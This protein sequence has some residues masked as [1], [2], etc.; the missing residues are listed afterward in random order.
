MLPYLKPWGTSEKDVND[1]NSSS[2]PSMDFEIKDIPSNKEDN[3]PYKCYNQI[4]FRFENADVEQ[5]SKFIPRRIVAT[6]DAIETLNRSGQ[7][8]REFIIRH[9]TGDWGDLCPED[10]KTNDEMVLHQKDRNSLCGKI[11]SSYR[12]SN[13]ERIWIVTDW[14]IKNPDSSVTCIL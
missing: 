9:V 4:E 6:P 1:V 10:K 8:P 3:D 11:I 7:E 5:R 12:T 2:F 14:I 13:G